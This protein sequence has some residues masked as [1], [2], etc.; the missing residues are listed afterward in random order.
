MARQTR[1]GFTLVELLVVIAIIAILVVMLLPAVQAARAAARRTQ[2]MNHFKQIGIA[3]HNYHS[4]YNVFCP[5]IFNWGDASEN[6]CSRP[7]NEPHPG[8]YHAW[9]WSV[10]ILPYLEEEGLEATFDF[11]ARSYPW[12][13]YPNAAGCQPVSIYLCPEDPQGFE[14]IRCC[15]APF[16]GGFCRTSNGEEDLGNGNVAA[17]ADSIDST[18]DGS[19][20][21][22]GYHY[23]INSRTAPADPGGY[24]PANGTLFNNSK[25]RIRDVRDGTSKTLMIGEVT[26]WHKGSHRGRY[27]MTGNLD[28][29][30]DGIN[31]PDTLP[32]G[33]TGTTFVRYDGFSS[34]H[35]G[36]GCH[37]SLVDGSVR[38]FLDEIDQGVLAALS[39]RDGGDEVPGI[40]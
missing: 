38:F 40:Y 2:C 36:G 18:C 19:S 17:V 13:S 22:L 6:G 26:G 11:N 5:G 32:G 37:F 9:S 8:S 33:Y 29:T 30:F 20:N 34:Y 16:S 4:S 3:L 39:T 31:G 21:R 10:F 14:L 7:V 15:T 27:W 12:A 24:R 28:D 35:P 25:T 23:D 1:N